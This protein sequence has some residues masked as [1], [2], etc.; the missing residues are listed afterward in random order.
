MTMASTRRRLVA[1]G[2]P[3]G[4]AGRGEFRI[5][6]VVARRS[7]TQGSRNAQGLYDAIVSGDVE[8]VLKLCKGGGGPQLLH[9]ALKFQGSVISS[10][11]L[12]AALGHATLVEVLLTQ[13]Q[14][15]PDLTVAS[16]GDGTCRMAHATPLWH[17]AHRCSSE[18]HVRCIETLVGAGAD[19]AP[20]G[21]SWP[22]EA[23]VKGGM[24]QHSK[25]GGQG[26]HRGRL[27]LCHLLASAPPPR[28]RGRGGGG[29][30]GGG[31]AGG[32]GGGAGGAACSRTATRAG[33]GGLGGVMGCGH[34]WGLAPPPCH[35][36]RKI[37]GLL[38]RSEP[39]FLPWGT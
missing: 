1:P 12:A 22:L 9:R 17:A 39:S 16:Q 13:F 34:G 19:P 7:V 11:A 14:L 18:G 10:L 24:I 26:G 36:P 5:R 3:A 29:G 8:L 30:G 32:G 33:M 37:H 25:S 28:G 15:P 20:P 38:K 2:A 23:A 21:I 31:G 4:G 35:P 6:R 27:S